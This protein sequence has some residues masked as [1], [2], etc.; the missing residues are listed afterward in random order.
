MNCGYTN[1][2]GVIVQYTT[3]TI[4]ITFPTIDVTTISEAYLVFKV[5]EVTVL[6][7]E[8]S[9]AIVGEKSL[10]WTLRQ[11]ETGGMPLYK[12]VRIYCDW[13]LQDGTRGRSKSADFTIVETGK[14]EVI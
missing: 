8:L 2:N 10:A 11:A 13:L 14:S 1:N 12:I 7:K 4:T 9:D 3:P 5:N 6:T